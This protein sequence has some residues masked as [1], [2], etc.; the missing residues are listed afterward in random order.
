MKSNGTTTI[1]NWA[2]MLGAV[3]LLVCGIKY[4]NKS[5]EVRASQILLAD[6][7]RLQTAQNIAVSLLN[8]TMEYS[9]SHPAI[10]PTLEAIGAKPSKTGAVIAPTNKPAAK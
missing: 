9:K 6:F 3:V 4:Y 2:L 1:L 5:K 10:E 7:N 8:E